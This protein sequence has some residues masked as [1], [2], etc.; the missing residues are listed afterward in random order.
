M[1]HCELAVLQDERWL[2]DRLMAQGLGRQ[3]AESKATLLARAGAVLRAGGAPASAAATACFVPGRI[4]VLGKHTDYAGGR[5]MVA[6]VERGVCLAAVVGQD[7]QL[8]IEDVATGQGHQFPLHADM[9]PREGHWL[10]YP[11]TVA[12]RVARNFGQPLCGAHIAFGS[13]LPP[14]AGMSS[15]SA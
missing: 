4:E 13:D 10:N 7:G 9:Q 15:S 11:M 12:R 3:A 5:S 1:S 2:T 14:A 8:V 6:A